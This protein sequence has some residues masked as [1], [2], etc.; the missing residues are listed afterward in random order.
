MIPI[1]NSSTNPAHSSST[2]K[3][4]SWLGLLKW[5]LEHIDGTHTS[6]FSAMSEE[7]KQWLQ[8][9]M[10]ELVKDENREM[11]DILVKWG[12]LLH[13]CYERSEGLSQE[14]SD[15][16]E[17]SIQQMIELTERIDNAQTFIKLKGSHYAEELLNSQLVGDRHKEL[18]SSLLGTL[19]QNNPDVQQYFF[20][21]NILFSLQQICSSTS[22]SSLFSKALYAISCTIRG[23]ASIEDSFC[24]QPANLLLLRRALLP[25]FQPVARRALFL[26]SALVS[27]DS[28][29]NA[30]CEA[31]AAALLPALLLAD[32]LL[33][34]VDER[35]NL[36]RLLLGLAKRAEAGAGLLKSHGE[37]LETCLR[38]AALQLNGGEEEEAEQ[39]EVETQLVR[40][41]RALVL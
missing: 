34:S 5:S 17:D 6:Q 38:G 2:Q 36:L 9:A 20:A 4:P 28:A 18:V 30:R 7:D 19:T 25:A 11:A 24:T 29:T 37:A 22:S 31:I 32:H 27:S 14:E 10:K 16:L 39:R 33:V 35:E 13:K 12:A 41:I 3:G 8:S 23:V 21:S 1:T 26:A 15:E 40:E